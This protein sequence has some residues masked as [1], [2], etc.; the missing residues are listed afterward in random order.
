[1]TIHTG[2]IEAYLLDYLEGN[3]DALLTAELMAFLSENPEYEKW[4]PE[5]NGHICLE[6]G[7]VF[8]DK[9][10]LKKNYTEIPL[11]NE[12][13]FEE[14]CIASAEGL[15]EKKDQARLDEYIE[16]HPEKLHDSDIYRKLVLQPDSLLV[17]PD[18]KSLKKREPVLIPLRFVYYAMGIAAS[19]ALLIM[20]VSRKPAEQV[21]SGSMPGKSGFEAI[22]KDKPVPETTIPT[23]SAGSMNPVPAVNQVRKKADTPGETATLNEITPVIQPL[24]AIEPIGARVILPEVSM[25]G[26]N[27]VSPYTEIPAPNSGSKEVASPSEPSTASILGSLVKKVNFWKAAEKAVTGFNYLTE[28]RLSLVR[29]TNENGKFSSLSLQSEDYDISDNKVK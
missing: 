4:I 22:Q 11:V 15:L 19:L 12:G 16:M 6:A 18:K 9:Q 26:I 1:M 10:I 5:Y 24:A 21:L 7:P 25:P 20:L 13:N 27:K 14:F 29:T 28:S 2:N 8:E 17:Y 3:L 23:V